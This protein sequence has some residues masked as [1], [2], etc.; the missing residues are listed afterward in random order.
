LGSPHHF[1]LAS[2]TA[3]V[4]LDPARDINFVIYPPAESMQ[5]LAD[6]KIDGL[7]SFSPTPQE[8][9][10]KKIGHVIL[11]SSIDRP[12]SQYFCCIVS[13]H[14]EFVRKH[15]VATKRALR[16]LLKAVDFCAAA[17]ER[18]A[19]ILA[20]RGHPYDYSLQTMREIP[21]AKWRDYDPE[22]AVRFYALRLREAGMI[23]S[24]PN[25]IIAQGT[26]WRFFN[27]LK[28]E[29]KS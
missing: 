10:T 23:K 8:L 14:R 3:Y 15:P 6:G 28:R 25:K 4:G 18:A 19:R 21:Y 16:A 27:E 12:W 17:P 29:L 2:I 1:F 26:D 5:L 11:N 20:D 13:G 24:T 7:L 22:D 9:R